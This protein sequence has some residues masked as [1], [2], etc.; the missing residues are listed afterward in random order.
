MRQKI[1]PKLP[2]RDKKLTKNFYINRS[3]FTEVGDWGDYLMISKDEIE[4]NLFLYKDLN[5]KENYGI[6]YIRT[7]DIEEIYQS[8]LDNGIK[9]HPNGKL[10]NKIWRQIEFLSLDPDNNLLTFGQA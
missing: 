4:I 3:G 8:F 2:I 7:S 10:E 5:P 1:T 9:I 6:I